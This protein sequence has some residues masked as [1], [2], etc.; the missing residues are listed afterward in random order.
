MLSAG[1]FTKHAKHWPSKNTRW[2]MPSEKVSGAYAYSKDQ[3]RLRIQ[4]DDGL[5]RPLTVESKGQKN[6]LGT[7]MKTW[8]WEYCACLKAPFCLKQLKCGWAWTATE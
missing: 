3:D 7:C 1:T 8:I 2:T 5:H 6:T 4:S